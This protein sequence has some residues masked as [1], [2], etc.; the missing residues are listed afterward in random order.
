MGEP[1]ENHGVKCD[2]STY[3]CDCGGNGKM[4]ALRLSMVSPVGSLG[5]NLEQPIRYL[6]D[7]QYPMGVFRGGAGH[8]LYRG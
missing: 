3:K 1:C 7:A 6:C 2:E 5:K 8:G 4:V